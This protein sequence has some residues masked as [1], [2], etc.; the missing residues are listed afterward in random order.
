MKPSDLTIGLINFLAIFLPGAIATALLLYAVP[1]LNEIAAA[2]PRDDAF[3]WIVGFAAAYVAGHIIFL[4]GSWLDP[5]Y[6]IIRRIRDPYGGQVERPK[7]RLHAATIFVFRKRDRRFKAVDPDAEQP[8]VVVD[9][10][11][12]RVLTKPEADATSNTFQWCRALLV[13]NS[14]AAHRDIEVQEADQK[15]LRSI[16]IL[17]L[18]VCVG[19]IVA[20]EWLVAGIILA[21]AIGSFARFYNRRL[22][23]VTLAYVH[24]MTLYRTGGVNF[25]PV[26]EGGPAA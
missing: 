13:Q 22:K 7:S 10:L 24:V 5:V 11:R 15:F 21:L 1:S 20:R 6:D 14:P 17:S 12:R 25:R 3:A 16:V 23:T 2:L 19:A 9:R 18:L 4:I 8:F 26:E